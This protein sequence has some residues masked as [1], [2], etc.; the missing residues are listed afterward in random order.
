MLHEIL[1]LRAIH[2]KPSSLQG[3]QR[4]N[5]KVSP[6]EETLKNWFEFQK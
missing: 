5:L 1:T 6:M 3:I 4:D 2:G